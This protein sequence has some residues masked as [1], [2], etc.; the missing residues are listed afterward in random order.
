MPISAYLRGLRR[1]VGTDLVLIPGVAAIVRDAE[2]RILFQRRS[3]DNQ[4]SLPA[5]SLDPGEEPARGIVREVWEETGLRVRPVRILGVVGGAAFRH[6]YPN[7][8]QIEP[9]TTVF[10]CR[11]EGGVLECRDGESQELRYFPPDQLPPLVMPYPPELLSGNGE[12]LAAF[13]QWDAAWLPPAEPLPPN[14]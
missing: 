11:V 1:K 7:G 9:T 13:F 10:E 4:W 8:D 2:G 5:G 3:D 14:Q 12:G 6:T